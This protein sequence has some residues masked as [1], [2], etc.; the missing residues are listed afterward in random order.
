MHVEAVIVSDMSSTGAVT[1]YPTA[2]V[3]GRVRLPGDKSISH[4]YAILAAIAD[5]PS[6]I[7]GF[8][9]GADCASTVTCLR[10][11]GVAIDDAGRDS[12]RGPT[13]HIAGRGLGGLR[14][15]ATVLDAGNSGSTM[16]M[17]AGL[18]A[19]HPF[20]S[21]LDGDNSLRR[22]PMRRVIAPLEGMGAR[23][24]AT[25]NRPPIT[26]TWDCGDSTH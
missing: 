22:R 17:L 6:I 10:S 25:D 2:R 7:H 24:T 9:T 23:I 5:G 15:P 20:D 21:T 12:E 8:S 1:V 3:R 19:A 26:G 18:L 13:L 4:R 16:R 11:L 14:A